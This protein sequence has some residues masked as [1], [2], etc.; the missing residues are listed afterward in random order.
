M[1]K[2]VRSYLVILLALA[3]VALA[4]PATADGPYRGKVIDAETKQP[5]EGAVVVA[6]WTERIFRPFKPKTVFREA[7][8]VFTNNNGEFEIPGYV[9]GKVGETALGV[10]YPHIYIFKPGYYSY[11]AMAHLA[12][13]EHQGR[14]PFHPYT[15]IELTFAKSEK[16]RKK[17]LHLTGVGGSVPN[18]K[19]Q[20][21]IK[22]INAERSSLGLQPTHLDSDG[23]Q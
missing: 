2:V 6:V 3:V 9:E 8:E 15:H 11:P 5:I 14:N 7:K 23:F 17:N 4:Q 21:W 18:K 1:P 16:E 20:N 13:I 19:V 10:Q 12:K 22:A